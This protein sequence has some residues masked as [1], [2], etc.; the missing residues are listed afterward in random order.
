LEKDERFRAWVTDKLR[1]DYDLVDSEF[2]LRMPSPLH[3]I[4]A[5]RLQEVIVRELKA[6][7]EQ[8]E[9]R[10]A[11]DS[12]KVA[13]TSDIRF[14]NTSGRERKSPDG[15][16]RFTGSKYPPLVIEV[17]NSQKSEDL[18]YLAESYIERTRG[19]TKTVITVDLEYRPP[20]ERAIRSLPLREAVYSIYRNRLSRNDQT[21]EWQ[22]EAHVDVEDQHFRIH[23]STASTG[24]MHLLLSD[25]C[26]EG[27][28]SSTN[29]RII[30][31]T[32]EELT[33]LLSEAEREEISAEA[34]SSPSCSEESVQFIS[35]RKRVSTPKLTSENEATF[36][37]AEDEAEARHLEENSSF[38]S[39][40]VVDVVV[41]RTKRIKTRSQQGF[42]QS[43]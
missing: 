32:H 20:E 29:D 35:K 9:V 30:T 33:K 17:A 24:S 1:Y 16:F 23:D 39:A 25:F 42:D 7:E 36:E 6:L 31:I 21:G 18:P 28:L 43:P 12:I 27:T 10:T 5:I 38:S 41:E 15:S 11:I 8:D 13:V 26:P 2:I 22:R 37:R 19:R 4:F 14:G 40:D 34:P 3:D